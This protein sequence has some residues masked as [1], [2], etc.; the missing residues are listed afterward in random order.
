MDSSYDAVS[1]YLQYLGV[2]RVGSVGFHVSGDVVEPMKL[3]HKP[4]ADNVESHGKGT[5]LKL[6]V[7]KSSLRCRLNM[8]GADI[9]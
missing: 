6:K 7:R 8:G 5:S 4:A 2:G 9:G 1:Q 3:G